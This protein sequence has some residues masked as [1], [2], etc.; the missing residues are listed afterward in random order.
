MSQS[1]LKQQTIS[2]MIWS[3]IG[4]FGTMGISFVS[5]I[6]LARLLMPSDYGAIA[7]I[8]IFIALSNLLI[9]GGF[10]SALIQ[11]K[12]ATHID[13]TSVFYWNVVISIILYVVL[14]FCSPAISRF[15][16]LPDLNIILRVQSISIIISAF[17]AV[18]TSILSKELKFKTLT[19]RN[20]IASICATAVSIVMAYC[21]L[22]VWS[23]VASNLIYSFAS[24]ILLWKMSPWR[25]TWEFS[26][27]SLKELFT[28]G[29]L[30]M[31]SSVFTK[32]FSELQGL[33]IGRYYTAKDLGYYHQARSLEQIPTESLTQIVT[34]VSFPVFSQLQSD[35]QRLM[36]AL[37]KNISSLT[38]ANFGL[39]TLLI[40]VATPLIRLLYGTQWDQS[41]PYFQILCISGMFL[42]L[43]N[44]NVSVIKALGKSKVLFFS[45]ISYKSIGIIALFVG[46]QFG[47]EGLL[48]AVVFSALVMY[49]MTSAINHRLIGYG[50]YQ[51]IKDVGGNLLVAIIA[52]FIAHLAGLILPLNQFVVMFIQVAI[53]L[54]IY[55][56][57]SLLVKLDG[58]FTYKDIVTDYINIIKN[59]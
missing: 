28:F 12:D 43:N 47:V 13:Y 26:F 38:Y 5:N 35:H 48:W 22:G 25:P 24:V 9:T 23:L 36:S 19:N 58:F 37:K 1:S 30:L 46:G 17:S 56:G 42:P 10:T 3:A 29:G 59:R 20:I 31:L 8:Q 4:K 39:V 51:Q 33:I 50:V 16:K 21:G 6:V 18:Q 11:K 49:F 2:G 32:L 57:I 53:Y 55:I 14:F 7:M 41:I 45:H 34:Q 15:Y 40:V 44:M 52:G 27:T 54:S